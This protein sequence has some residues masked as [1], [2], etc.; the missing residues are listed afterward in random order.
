[1]A[2]LEDRVSKIE[3]RNT[4]VTRD[5]AWETSYTRKISI[6]WLTYF[7]V[8]LFLIAIKNDNPFVNSLIPVGSYIFSTLGLNWI[9]RIWEDKVNTTL[10][11]I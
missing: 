9:R 2:K 11:K 3:A 6:T 8:L 1:M 4:S 10:E 5:K 7:A